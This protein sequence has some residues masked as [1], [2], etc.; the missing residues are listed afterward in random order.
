MPRP[1]LPL[2][3]STLL[4][5]A[6]VLHHLTP[7]LHKTA[8]QQCHSPTSFCPSPTPVSL[9]SDLQYNIIFVYIVCCT[10]CF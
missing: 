4:Y 3:G 5:S 2:R 7:A 10:V 8:L 6:P 9:V 1:T